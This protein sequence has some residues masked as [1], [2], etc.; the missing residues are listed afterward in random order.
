VRNRDIGV[1]ALGRFLAVE[2][3]REMHLPS[4]THSPWHSGAD[5][6]AGHAERPDPGS[7]SRAPR[8]RVS[9]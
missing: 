2:R 6:T 5:R 4:S 9:S 3:Y 7:G 1:V 8:P